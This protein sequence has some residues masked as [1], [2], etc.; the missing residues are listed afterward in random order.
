M[1]AKAADF[2]PKYA[3]KSSGGDVVTDKVLSWAFVRSRLDSTIYMQRNLFFNKDKSKAIAAASSSVGSP[4]PYNYLY[5]MQL[6]ATD[7]SLTTAQTINGGIGNYPYTDIN[8]FAEI[9]P[10]DSYVLFANNALIA[11]VAVNSSY[12]LSNYQII[13]NDGLVWTKP[14]IIN[15]TQFIS[16]TRANNRRQQV[17]IF[18]YDG[19]TASIIKTISVGFD[20]TA[21]NIITGKYLIVIG[22]FKIAVIDIGTEE[23]LYSETAAVNLSDVVVAGAYAFVKTI[24]SQTNPLFVYSVGETVTKIAFTIQG[25]ILSGSVMSPVNIIKDDNQTGNVFL[26]VYTSNNA[27]NLGLT[28]NLDKKLI[29]NVVE[30]ANTLVGT[31]QG[32]MPTFAAGNRLFYWSNV[33]GTPGT[34]YM[35][36]FQYKYTT[37]SLRFEGNFYKIG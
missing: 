26:L 20:I 9:S 36:Q 15:A 35:A 4:T 24:S 27:L 32:V 23:I 25:T 29:S 13:Y 12:V 6:N 2:L 10:D 21:I 33:S 34:T 19:S 11:R 14:R 5:R 18:E 31:P 8:N 17:A 16:F 28:I 3:K 22:A 37:V 1:M 30:G 7:G